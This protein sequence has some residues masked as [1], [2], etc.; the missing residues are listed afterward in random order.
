MC[1]VKHLWYAYSKIC[2]SHLQGLTSQ[3]STSSAVAA[4]ELFARAP[5]ASLLAAAA[6]GIDADRTNSSQFRAFVHSDLDLWQARPVGATS[7][8]DA[9][10]SASVYK[11]SRLLITITH[12]RLCAA[13]VVKGVCAAVD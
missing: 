11:A 12:L 7:S 3:G 9:T 1:A 4:S 2:G 8:A 5:S 10:T 6:T 13:A